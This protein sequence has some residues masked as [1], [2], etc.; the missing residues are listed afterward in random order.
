MKMVAADWKRGTVKFE[1]TNKD[2]LWFLSHIIET[3]DTLTGRTL[4]KIKLGDST[5]KNVNV[6]KK[7][8]TVTLEAEKVDFQGETLRILGKTTE[9]TED[10]PKGSYHTLEIEVGTTATLKK[11]Q[12]MKFQKEKL[13][14]ACEEK[15]GN[16]MIL[17]VER[18]EAVFAVL[19][20]SGYKI[21]AEI[22]GEV[23]KKGYAE[24]QEKDFYGDIAKN[25]EDYVE[26]YKTEQII[27]ASPSFWKENILTILKKRFPATA[28]KVTLATCNNLG[29]TGIEEI[30]PCS[31]PGPPREPHPHA[32]VPSRH[33]IPGATH[34]LCRSGTC[35]DPRPCI[36]CHKAFSA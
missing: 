24:I 11:E 25:L 19:T 27:I 7:L 2:D 1:V 22:G 16:I 17:A 36:P 13:H 4:R 26:R 32:P 15:R 30:R 33:A 8:V 5:E 3:K 35:C 23:G 18:D 12:W 14:E 29:K 6:I 9:G 10:I 21:L 20:K 28:K 34:H 31:M